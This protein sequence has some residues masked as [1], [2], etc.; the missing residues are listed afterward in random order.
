MSLTS[1]AAGSEREIQAAKV[2]LKKEGT[3]IEN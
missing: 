2:I 3:E 1:D